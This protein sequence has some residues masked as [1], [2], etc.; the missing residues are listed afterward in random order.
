M[1]KKLLLDVRNHDEISNMKLKEN[2]EISEVLYIPSNTVKFNLGF[3]NSYFKQ[4]EQVY[5]ICRSGN[6]SSQ[7]KDKYFK[8]TVN[9]Q[10]YK[11][12]YNNIPRELLEPYPEKTTYSLVRKIQMIMGSIL[13]IVFVLS[14]YFKNIF[15][16]LLPFSLFM[17]Y[18]GISGNCF[19]SS[20][21]TKNDI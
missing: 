8:K 19:M 14:F 4:F 5:I 12:N 16:V 15:Y 1:L 20:I 10:L 6:R 2:T 17:L 3:L 13:L 21:L 11:Y 18:V 9:V 7:I